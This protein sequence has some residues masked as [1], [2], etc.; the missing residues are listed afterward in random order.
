[1]CGIAGLFSQEP[2]E[3]KYIK[4]MTDIIKHRGPDSEGQQALFDGKIWLGHRRLSILDLSSAGHQP[5]SYANGRYWITYNGEVYNYLELRQ[6]LEKIG[7]SFK[8]NADTEV[9]LA[10]YDEWGRECLHRF[11]GMWAFLIV[12]TVQRQVF[13]A[14]DRFGVKPLYYWQSPQGVL[15]FASEI[16]QFT[17]L[18]GW[19]AAMN[20]QRV[21]DFLNWGLTDH[22]NET[23]FNGV[24]QIRGGQAAEFSFHDCMKVLPVYQ[25]YELKPR[26][27]SGDMQ[28]AAEK[29]RNLFVDAVRLRL[30]ADVPVGSCLSGG[31]D[32]SSIVCVVNDLLKSQNA[33]ELQKTVS[34]CADIKK[35]DEREFI[36]QVVN[37][38]GIEAYYTY[39]QPDNLFEIAGRLTW[40]Q[41]E[42]FGSTSIYAQWCVFKLAAEQGLKVMLDGQGADEELAGYHSFFAPKFAGMFKRSEWVRLLQEIIACRKLHNYGV[43]FALKG[44]VNMLFPEKVRQNIRK[45]SGHASVKPDWLNLG[46]L[47]AEP[48]DPFVVN[49]AKTDTIQNLSIAQLTASNLQMLLHWEDRDSMAHSV[50]SRLPFL[51]YRLVEFVL[52][53]PDEMKL[54]K[55]VTKR[56]LREGMI[57]TLPEKIRM[58][59]DKM[60]FVTPEEI[61]IKR[62]P[63][64][65]MEE[66]RKAQQVSRG[67]LSDNVIERLEK[68]VKGNIPFSFWLWRVIS[69][70]KWIEQYG[71]N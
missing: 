35:Y 66:V 56:V 9:I 5:L 44:M 39:P 59:T 68:M 53:L 63:K 52:G 17:V 54:S 34:A 50:E 67:V 20:G 21:Y 1:M 43:M 10:A 8:S 36:D 16:K 65:F 32:S 19:K 14:R 30:R 24:V 22:T 49:G 4:Q 6:E 33:Q 42:P 71:V 55:G 26:S 11:N 61:W 70:G 45:Y 46:K 64:L 38:H 28:E 12:D 13:A 25:W 47:G 7:Y 37:A 23:L 29:F 57:G 62:N 51:D 18:P 2:I 58:R 40:Y 3:Y 48:I 60:G 27:F 31:L 41:D 15:A 69:F